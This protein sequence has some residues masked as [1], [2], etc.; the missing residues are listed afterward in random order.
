[1]HD[2]LADLPADTAA[3]VELLV[4]LSSY[5]DA[6]EHFDAGAAIGQLQLALH[7]VTYVDG[8]W[9]T[10]ADALRTVVLANGGEIVEGREASSVSADG[11]AFVVVAGARELTASAVVIAAGGPESAARLLGAP[12]PG[13]D[14]LGPACT[15]RHSIS[16]CPQRQGPWRRSCSV[17]TGRCTYRSMRPWRSS[18]HPARCSFR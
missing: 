2:W 15:R 12:V 8:G 4:R 6:P 11:E 1:M 13:A 3:I 14:R 10:L 18:P 9:Q 5:T 16:V 17:S 7:G